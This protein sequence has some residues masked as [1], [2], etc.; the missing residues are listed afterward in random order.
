MHVLVPLFTTEDTLVHPSVASMESQSSLEGRS[1]A[2]ASDLTDILPSHP[3]FQQLISS[4]QLKARLDDDVIKMKRLFGSLVVKTR[5]SV[6]VRISVGM[7]A[8]SILALGAYEPA[9]GERDQRLLDE[10]REEI[11]SAKSVSEIFI[12]LSPYWNY[13]DYEILVYIIHH[14]GTSDDTERLRKYNEELHNFFKRRI[15]KLPVESGSGIGNEKS[16]RQKKVSVMLDVHEGIRVEE[17]SQIK[18]KIAKILR[19]NPSTLIIQ[20]VEEGI[21]QLQTSEGQL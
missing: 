16:L 20:S 8:R 6:E 18:R 3:P 11:N 13:L 7:L 9:V 21:T 12:I 15:F 19:V 1:E 4:D 17:I 5:D 2:T 10:H 14:Y